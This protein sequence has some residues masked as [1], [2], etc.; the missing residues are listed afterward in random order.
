M[1]AA[2]L[3]L[4]HRRTHMAEPEVAQSVQEANEASPF[5]PPKLKKRAEEM[6]RKK[7]DNTRRSATQSAKYYAS[8]AAKQSERAEKAEV[9]ARKEAEAWAEAW[10]LLT[11]AGFKPEEHG[12]QTFGIVVHT[13]EDKLTKL[14]NTIGRLNEDEMEK[15]IEDAAKKTVKIT[16]PAV[17]YPNVRVSF[18]RK[19][20][21]SDK[22]K[23]VEEVVP[24]RVEARL[25]CGID[26]E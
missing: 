21:D 16:I 18:I 13:T 14:Y 22:C 7:A 8:E 3:P 15:E 26:R 4:A 6:A 9:E 1:G 10:S 23:I 19:L 5:I 25:V 2:F 12:W 20:T 17:K 24:S 11:K